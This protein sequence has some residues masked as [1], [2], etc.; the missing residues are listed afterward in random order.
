MARNDDG[1]DTGDG[2][3]PDIPTKQKVA[4]VMVAL[5]EDVS[6]EVMKHL[7]DFEIEEVTQGIASLKNISSDIIDQVI[8]EFA[9]LLLAGEWIAQGGMDFA[10]AARSSRWTRR[11][12]S[13]P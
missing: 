10:R 4:I 2:D 3:E 13:S 8:G 9:Q 1:R 7:S 6:G 12:W 5:G 11:T